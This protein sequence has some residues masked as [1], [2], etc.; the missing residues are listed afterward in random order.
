MTAR[1]I[2]HKRE[3]LRMPVGEPRI[4]KAGADGQ[5]APVIDIL[6]ERHFAQA[7]HDRVIMQHDGGIIVT[8]LRDRLMQRASAD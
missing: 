4:A 8:D 2:S 5:H 1:G 3:L 6:H 7:L